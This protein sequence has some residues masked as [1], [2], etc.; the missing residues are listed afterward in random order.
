M[1]Y[2][3]V[4]IRKYR[5]RLKKICP[6]IKTIKETY[7]D[8]KGAIEMICKEFDCGSNELLLTKEEHLEVQRYL[9]S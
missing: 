7:G 3:S 5:A 2:D 8:D 4:K 9:H 6:T 1:Y